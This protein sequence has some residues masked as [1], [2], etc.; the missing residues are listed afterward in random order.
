MWSVCVWACRVPVFSGGRFCCA[1][2]LYAPPAHVL[3]FVFEFVFRFVFS[4][5]S[6]SRRPLSQSSRE[7]FDFVLYFVS[8][9]VFN[10]IMRKL[11]DYRAP[12][13]PHSLFCTFPCF[14][15]ATFPDSWIPLP[16]PPSDAGAEL[17]Q[18]ACGPAGGDSRRRRDSVF[19]VGQNAPGPV[20]AGRRRAPSV[21]LGA[22]LA[23]RICFLFPL[24]VF[25][26]LFTGHA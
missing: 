17:C 12:K 8:C 7:R 2:L 1:N 6:Q 14:H 9:F 20:S 21:C 16:H 24:H 10:L 4:L 19:N 26:I 23:G 11:L 22:G 5:S 25:F 13:F 18:I 3:Y 15:I